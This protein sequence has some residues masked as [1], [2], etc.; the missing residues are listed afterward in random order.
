M[1]YPEVQVI[2]SIG[3]MDLEIEAWLD[4][5][6]EGGIAIPASMEHDILASAGESTVQVAD[7]HQIIVPTWM[8]SV[9]IAEAVFQCEVVAL[10]SRVLLGLQ[11]M[12]R[13]DVLF[14]RGARVRCYLPNGAEFVQEYD[15]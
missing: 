12:D 9:E 8:G 4:T 14:Q 3:T 13:M 1:R 2:L 7:G 15:R 5:G 11:V 10:G 6:F